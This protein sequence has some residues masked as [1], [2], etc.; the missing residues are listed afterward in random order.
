MPENHHEEHDHAPDEG[1]DNPDGFET[2]QR[3]FP[4]QPL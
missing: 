1:D 2:V 4:P 3:V